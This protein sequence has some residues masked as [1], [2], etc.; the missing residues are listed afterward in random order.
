MKTYFT[1][2]I[3]I[4][5][6]G[7]IC[8]ARDF[9]FEFIEENYRET[10]ADFSYQPIIYHSIQVNSTLGPKLLILKGDDYNYRKWFRQ[11]ISQ[12]K[13]FIAIIA[14]ERLDEFISA[15][16]YEI[17]I[18]A[19]HPFNGDK[20][21]TDDVKPPGM[22]TMEGDNHILIV[23][24]NEKRTR[25]I[26]SV[27]EKMQY[28]A[29]IFT[30]GL[31]ALEVFKLQPGKFKMAIIYF[32]KIGIP[33]DQLIEQV[34]KLNQSIPVVLDTG[35]NNESETDKF[36]KKFSGSGSI[37]IKPVMLRDLQKTIETLIKKN[38]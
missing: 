37:H 3:W 18:K 21:I 34:V 14:D 8:F 35:Y 2:F 11:Y 23:D 5:I 29:D 26:Q 33:S 4:L 38:A 24:P 12:N 1:V 7:S 30:D 6:A 13:K 25:L 10:Q 20:W 9:Q 27:V 15:K 28:R 16:A 19:I 31:A 17:D 36:I 22:N 32:D